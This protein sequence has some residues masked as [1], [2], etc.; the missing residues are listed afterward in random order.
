M[1]GKFNGLKALILSDNESAFYVHCFAHQLQLVIVAVAKKHDGVKDF[2]DLLA[3]MVTVVNSSCK[4]KD[5]IRESHKDRIQ[6]E[7][8]NEEIVTGKGLNQEISLVQAGDT[9][10]NSHHKTIMSLIALFPEVVKVLEYVQED[11]DNAATRLQASGILSYLKTFEFV[12]YMHLML[13]IFG[14]T[15]SLSQALQRKDQDVMEAVSLIRTTKV[16]LQMLRENGFD[17]LV[18]KC[19]SLCDKH[20]I[21]KL[22]MTE[23]YVNPR[24]PRKRMNISNQHIIIT[25]YLTRFWICRFESLVIV[26]VR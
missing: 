7:I 6:V 26:F 5:M 14:L 12:F 20:N 23:G 3:L 11:G 15:N 21:A 24:N 1:S 8:G 16:Q 10:W 9:R 25:I 19:Y 4:R 22:D 2:F 13:T 17:Q 18:E